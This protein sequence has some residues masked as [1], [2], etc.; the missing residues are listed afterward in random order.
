MTRNPAKLRQ[1]V[2]VALQPV[3]TA[4]VEV[5]RAERMDVIVPSQ[6]RQMLPQ[7]CLVRSARSP[8]ADAGSE[9]RWRGPVL[10]D[11]CA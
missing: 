4:D 11:S 2:D 1:Y 5:E 7:Q 8:V 10:L 9:L 3:L 6:S